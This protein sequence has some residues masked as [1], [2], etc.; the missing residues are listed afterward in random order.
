MNLEAIN[1][2]VD[3]EYHINK[4]YL[5]SLQELA[6]QNI[7]NFY[8]WECI[9]TGLFM[10]PGMIAMLGLKYLYTHLTPILESFCHVHRGN[11]GRI[12]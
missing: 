12:G 1:N 3:H 9:L 5:R 8:G 10:G 11:M 4:L 2:T 6:E 7:D